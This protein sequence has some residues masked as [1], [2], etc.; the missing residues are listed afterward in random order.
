MPWSRLFV[1]AVLCALALPATAGAAK[2][3]KAPSPLT[4]ASAVGGR[5]WGATP[6]GGKIKVLAQRPLP[7]GADPDTAVLRMP[8]RKFRHV[9]QVQQGGRPLAREVELDHHVRAAPDGERVRVS[10]AG[11]QCL[12]PSGGLQELHSPQIHPQR[13]TCQPCLP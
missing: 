4:A 11:F 8:A 10:G 3:V 7:A 6:C 13:L 12:P 5:Y 9:R 1:A 2:R